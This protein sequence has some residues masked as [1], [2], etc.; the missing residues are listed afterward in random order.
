MIRKILTLT[1]SF[2]LIS[3]VSIAEV[4]RV[5]GPHSTASGIIINKETGCMLTADH[6]IG[7]NKRIAVQNAAG[8]SNNTYDV[9]A[10]ALA[11]DIA[12]LCPEKYSGEFRGSKLSKVDGRLGDVILIGFNPQKGRISVSKGTAYT[13]YYDVEVYP[14]VYPKVIGI[15]DLLG[16]ATSGFSGGAV[17]LDGEVIGMIVLRSQT[18]PIFYATVSAELKSFLDKHEIS[19]E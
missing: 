6:V 1:V 15:V 16:D 12:V 19:Y 9:V 13:E 17:M 8:L 18:Q 10:K 11:G 14:H 4:V 5:I 3:A 7:F 2:L